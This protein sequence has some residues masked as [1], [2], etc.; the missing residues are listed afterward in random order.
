MGINIV[1]CVMIFTL[2]PSYCFFFIFCF[3]KLKSVLS[4]KKL[5][6]KQSKWWWGGGEGVCEAFGMV[7]VGK[8]LKDI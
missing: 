5:L 4:L 7:M 1:P 8:R 3:F 6:H 2:S